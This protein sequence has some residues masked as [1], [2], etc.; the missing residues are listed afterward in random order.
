MNVVWLV[1]LVNVHCMSFGDT[2]GDELVTVKVRVI[3][4]LSIAIT[5]SGPLT[6]GGTIITNIK[7]CM[8]SV[9]SKQPYLALL[10]W[11]YHILASVLDLLHCFLLYK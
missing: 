10:D 11:L 7:T 3:D 1:A 4:K 6:V 5:I 2:G 9:M 8:A